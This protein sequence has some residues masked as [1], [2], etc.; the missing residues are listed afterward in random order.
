MIIMNAI[1]IA[2]HGCGENLL[3]KKFREK[4]AESETEIWFTLFVNIKFP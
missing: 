1:A 2:D 4:N 3:W